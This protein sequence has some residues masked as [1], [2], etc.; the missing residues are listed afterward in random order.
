MDASEAVD[1]SERDSDDSIDQL[2][3]HESLLVPGAEARDGTGESY[4]AMPS[5]LVH[6]AQHGV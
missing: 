4:G 5:F 6:G 3:P 2:D 1:D